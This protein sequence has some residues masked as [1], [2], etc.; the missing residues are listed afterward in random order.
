LQALPRG[1]LLTPAQA[2]QFLGLS[3]QRVDQLRVSGQLTAV[4]ERQKWMYEPEVLEA[5]LA[6]PPCKLQPKERRSG[7]RARAKPTVPQELPPLEAQTFVVAGDG[8]LKKLPTVSF[9]RPEPPPPPSEKQVP[10][11]LEEFSEFLNQDGSFNME[12]CRSWAEFEK[13]RK[14]QVE[15]L[16]AEGKYVQ[17]SEIAPAWQKTLI[18]INRSVMAIPNR[19]KAD[20]PDMTLNE[21]AQLEKLCREALKTAAAEVQELSNAD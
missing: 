19:M 15:R 3:R 17:E 12:R 14:L 13:A 21:V 6:N 11:G 16:A 5:F 8:P 7:P 2:A 18:S 10:A 1:V 9:A 20:N 4:G